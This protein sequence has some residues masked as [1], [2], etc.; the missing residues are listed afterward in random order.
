MDFNVRILKLPSMMFFFIKWKQFTRI[1]L[2]QTDYN[3]Q[4]ITI[5]N[6]K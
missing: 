3:N 5:A 6:G 2:G 4:M 1:T